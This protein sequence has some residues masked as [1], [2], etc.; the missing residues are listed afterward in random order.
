[1]GWT[2]LDGR[3]EFRVALRCAL[4]GPAETRL[5]AGGGIVEGAAPDAELAETTIKL[6]ALLYA[7]TDD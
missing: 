4:T 1:M 3:G 2:T 5:F 7:L 6:E